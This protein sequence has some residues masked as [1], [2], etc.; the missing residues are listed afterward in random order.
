MTDFSRQSSTVASSANNVDICLREISG[1]PGSW[2]RLWHCGLSHDLRSYAE[3][4]SRDGEAKRALDPFVKNQFY[5]YFTDFFTDFHVFLRVSTFLGDIHPTKTITFGNCEVETLLHRFLRKGR[6]QVSFS[7]WP[8][9]A[10]TYGKSARS[11]WS[12]S[13]HIFLCVFVS[14]FAH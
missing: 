10:Q 9:N 11:I 1:T 3:L 4:E 6:R 5:R 14:G 7:S 12:W 8:C 13:F 2:P